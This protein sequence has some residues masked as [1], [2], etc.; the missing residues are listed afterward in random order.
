[1]TEAE[2][3]ACTNPDM[4]LGFLRDELREPSKRKLRLFICACCRRIWDVLPDEHSRMA[5]ETAEA[6]ADLLIPPNVLVHAHEAA[7]TALY[8]ESL[9]ADLPGVGWGNAP[10]ESASKLMFSNLALQA[11]EGAARAS[12]TNM[13]R[14]KRQN[15]QTRR[16]IWTAA[17]IAEK[18]AQ[19]HLLR[20]IFGNPYRQKIVEPEWPAWKGGTARRLA[21]E[22]HDGRS[23]PTGTLDVATLAVLADALEEAG[24]TNADILDHRRRPGVHV[25]GCWVIDLLLGKS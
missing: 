1:M 20:D 9:I 13:T 19:C 11:A 6:Y 3:Q 21:Q 18:R 5:V 12:A 17:W 24:C 25:R 7:T 16:R 2:W 23:L 8:F 10:R 14:S 15:V 4:M 22:A